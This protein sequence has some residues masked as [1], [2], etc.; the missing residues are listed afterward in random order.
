MANENVKII[1][2]AVN[3]TGRQLASVTRGLGRVGLQITKVTAAFGALSVA[4]GVTIVRS[5]LKAI[6]SLGK[7]AAKIGVATE[8]L[9]AMRFA[10][11]LTG[12]SVETMDMALQRYIRRTAE[13]ARGTGEAVGALKE[14]GL[15][16]EKLVKLGLNDQMDL[17]AESFE[18]VENPADRVRLAMK[19][20]DSEGVS[21]VGTLQK[22]SGALDEMRK[23]ADALGILFDSLDVK[24]VEQAND[25]LLKVSKLF[26]G[27]FA[28]ATIELAPFIAEIANQLR[29]AALDAG[30]FDDVAV[31][32]ITN[33]LNGLG[34][35]LNAYREWR[36]WIAKIKLWW[37]ESIE[38]QANL[39]D[40]FLIKKFSDL[41]DAYKAFV[42]YWGGTAPPNP[43]KTKIQEIR[44]EI[45]AATADLERLQTSPT[46]DTAMKAMWDSILVGARKR[47]EVLEDEL[48]A[49]K[50]NEDEDEEQAKK[51]KYHETIWTDMA[52]KR[53]AFEESSRGEQAMQ[54][55]QHMSTLFA[56]NKKMQIA[57]ALMQ[58]YSGATK[59]FSQYGGG[60][61]GFAMAAAVVAAGLAQVQNIKAQSFEGGGF[62]GHGSRSGGLDGRGGF[63]GMLHPNESVIDHTRGGSG[64][65]TV[66]NNIDATNADP[67]AEL[68]I[69]QAMAETSQA[70]IASIQN[71]MRRRRFT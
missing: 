26:E 34:E 18:N 61:V 48:K 63:L 60:P 49:K 65:V 58:T 54:I 13:A 19:L 37:A 50:D 27:A 70:T 16:A 55:S 21:L 51:R 56:K 10:G 7:T 24:K 20:F 3:K 32:F 1:L 52:K 35:V 30:G 11:E 71:L 44:D 69:R 33:L 46:P 42:E 68:R 14:L 8:A 15:D 45:A 9:G 36:I 38:W 4:A 57:N 29:Q 6:D 67:G 39:L 43:I 28:Q 22:G 2:T 41:W 59:A 25:E 23:E 47:V 5:N 17:L 40:S 66:V 62:T 12:V 53:A 64:G 31:K